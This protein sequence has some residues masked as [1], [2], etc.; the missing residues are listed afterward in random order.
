MVSRVVTLLSAFLLIA[1]VALAAP[2]LCNISGTVYNADGSGDANDTITII[3]NPSTQVI[4][5]VTVTAKPVSVQTDA[6]GNITPFTL[7]QG[8]TVNVTYQNGSATPRTTF[9]PNAPAAPWANFVSASSTITSVSF[10]GSPVTYSGLPTSPQ[11]GSTCTVTDAQVCFLTVPVTIGG[12]QTPCQVT[13]IGSNWF[14]AGNASIRPGSNNTFPLQSNANFNN[15]SATNVNAIGL[16]QLNPPGALGVTATC[17][18]TCATTYTYEVTCVNDAGGETLPTGSLTSTNAAA[19]DAGH[20]NVISWAAQAGCTGGY[21]VY[22]RIGGSLGELANVPQGI[23]SYVDAGV[24]FAPTSYTISFGGQTTFAAATVW[25][26][27]GAKGWIDAIQAGGSSGFPNG[28]TLTAPGFTTPVNHDLEIPVFGWGPFAGAFTPPAGFSNPVTVASS[29][30]APDQI[31]IWGG[32]K[33]IPVAT[34]VPTQSG[35]TVNT[36]AWAALH[37]SFI[38]A[39]T[40]TPV[41]IVGTSSATQTNGNGMVLTDPVGTATGDVELICISFGTNSTFTP[42]PNFPVGPS[43]F[44]YLGSAGFGTPGQ[45]GINGADLVCYTN[46]PLTAGSGK[47]PPTYNTT[48]I[49]KQS[50]TTG[51]YGRNAAGNCALGRQQRQLAERGGR[52][53]SDGVH[54]VSYA[55]HCDDLLYLVDAVC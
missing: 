20:F 16:N 15:Y 41:T 49:L 34:P 30:V 43:S 45:T 35:S 31:G 14:P 6:S 7:V 47:K 28:R 9:V 36:S 23:F 2:S 50:A 4:N 39:S 29:N 5:N 1:R 42:F 46:V 24:A 8:L 40:S 25:D 11:I 51:P 52:F 53:R 44:N 3:P 22:G 37:F 54:R 32:T 21:N 18:G 10:C 38:P 12:G 26:L 27:R 33:D 19:L 13:W 48:G 17:S 55:A